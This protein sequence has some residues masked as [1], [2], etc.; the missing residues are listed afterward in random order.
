MI[1]T[2]AYRRLK[3]K[4]SN[5]KIGKI[6][7]HIPTPSEKDYKNGYIKRYFIQK[8]N[9]ANA[10]IFEISDDTFQVYVNSDFFSA[11]V[12]FWKISG[13]SDEIRKA[14]KAS[15]KTAFEKIPNLK[16]YLPNLLQF[17]K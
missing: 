12:I 2:T 1:S 3:G 8:V 16:N 6:Y 11:V 14:N 7:T 13:D 10:H 9:D 4:I 5:F 17:S 15:I